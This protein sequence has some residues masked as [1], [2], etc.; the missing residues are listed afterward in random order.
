MKGKKSGENIRPV[1]GVSDRWKMSLVEGISPQK[2]HQQ[3]QVLYQIPLPIATE[4]NQEECLAASSVM[5]SFLPF[6]NGVSQNHQQADFWLAQSKAGS[7]SQ[8]ADVT[9]CSEQSS[10]LT[11]RYQI[12][13]KWDRKSSISVN[14]AWTTSTS[15]TQCQ[16]SFKE[17]KINQ[18]PPTHLRRFFFS[19]T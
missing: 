2:D 5:L 13:G 3:R 17:N 1:L 19:C 4:Q 10:D 14:S 7:C 6:V 12:Q 9:L 16:F 11:I 15:T 8:L 18:H